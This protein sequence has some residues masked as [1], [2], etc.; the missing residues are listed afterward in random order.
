LQIGP[1]TSPNGRSSLM[2]FCP[3]LVAGTDEIGVTTNGGYF[4][5]FEDAN[6]G[7]P[8]FAV[9]APHPPNHQHI[10]GLRAE[11]WIA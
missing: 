4:P 9:Q 6:C 11:P 1:Y 7:R 3:L 10:F 8:T 2:L 5:D